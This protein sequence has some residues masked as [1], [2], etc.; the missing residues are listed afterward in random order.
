VAEFDGIQAS[1]ERSR[2][3]RNP[4]DIQR[5]ADSG[6]SG[7]PPPWPKSPRWLGTSWAVI[8]RFLSCFPLSSP[9]SYI[10]IGIYIFSTLLSTETS[11]SKGRNEISTTSSL[12]LDWGPTL[13]KQITKVILLTTLINQRFVLLHH[14]VVSS[15]NIHATG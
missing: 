15:D 12:C 4:S 13:P 8:V 10:C 6:M 2:T 3:R 7:M 14:L 11:S 9:L 1:W 5:G